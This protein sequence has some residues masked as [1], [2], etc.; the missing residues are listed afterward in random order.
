MRKKLV[1]ATKNVSYGRGGGWTTETQAVNRGAIALMVLSDGKL[2]H[3]DNIADKSYAIAC[4]AGYRQV[5]DAYWKMDTG[6]ALSRLVKVGK[7]VR[8]APGYFVTKDSE[9]TGKEQFGTGNV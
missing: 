7:V 5:E 1:W 4:E 2:H 3:L 9:V 6:A 8:I